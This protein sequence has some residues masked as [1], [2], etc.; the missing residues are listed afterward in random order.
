MAHWRTQRTGT[1]QYITTDH[2]FLVIVFDDS[3]IEYRRAAAFAFVEN[4]DI[5]QEDGSNN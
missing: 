5:L 4:V 1:V 2:Q 3:K